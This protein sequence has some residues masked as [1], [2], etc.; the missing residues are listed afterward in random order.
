MFLH[1][2]N[3]T[4]QNKNSTMMP[5]SFVEMH[6][7]SAY[8]NHIVF[9]RSLRH[10]VRTRLVLHPGVVGVKIQSDSTT[11]Y[12]SVKTGMVTSV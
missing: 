8:Q 12:E 11:V 2:N 6:G 5:V 9:S 10:K 1:C 7:W 3:S 4:G